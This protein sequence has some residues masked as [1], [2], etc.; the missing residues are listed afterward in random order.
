MTETLHFIDGQFVPSRSGK[1]FDKRS[2]LDNSLMGTVAEGGLEEVDAA[3]M[4][5]RRALHGDW[6]R[7]PVDKRVAMLHAVADGITQRFG[8]L[9]PQELSAFDF[10]LGREQGFARLRW[11]VESKE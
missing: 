10:P 2:P 5:A 4:A 9:S 6:G 7:L 8:E 1:T 3:V 11:L